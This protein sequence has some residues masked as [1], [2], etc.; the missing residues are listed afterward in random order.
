MTDAKPPTGLRAKAVSI[1]LM[2]DEV[3]DLEEL[4]SISDA[5]PT[6]LYRAFVAPKVRAGLPILRQM[7]A[8]G[9]AIDT[10]HAPETIW[11]TESTLEEIERLSSGAKDVGYAP[12]DVWSPPE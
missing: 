6:M 3:A 12:A 2:P 7:I 5:S 4:I 8:S 11:L 1:S 9:T 10:R